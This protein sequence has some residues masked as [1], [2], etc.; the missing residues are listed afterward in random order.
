MLNIT[1]KLEKCTQNLMKLSMVEKNFFIKF[2][3]T[4]QIFRYCAHPMKISSPDEISS[5]FSSNF[6]AIVRGG[7]DDDP[8]WSCQASTKFHI[9][10]QRAG[11]EDIVRLIVHKYS[12]DDYSEYSQTAHSCVRWDALRDPDNG[13]NKNDTVIV[14]AHVTAEMPPNATLPEFVR[15]IS[16]PPDAFLILGSKRIPIHK[17]Y[18][19]CYSDFF[20]TM[21]QSEFKEGREEEIVLEDVGYNEMTQLLS[22]IYPSNAP[23]TEWNIKSILKLADR[24]IMPVITE[25]CKKTLKNSTDINGAKKLL[26]AQRYNFT[27]L[28]VEL[29]R[30]YRTV[31]DV[32]KLKSE[33]EF[34][35]LDHNTIFLILNSIVS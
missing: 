24:F 27:D 33:P 3:T 4:H 26:L 35:L 31:E 21:F 34:E 23:I 9:V 17:M 13:F 6:F 11:I 2:F 14:Q 32:K 18:L 29:A 16:D 25:R 20:K 8:N 5:K 19:S 28:Q 30:Q 22:V 10:S 7:P 12:K 15:S 1:K